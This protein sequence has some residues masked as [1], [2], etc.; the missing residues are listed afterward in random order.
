M[1]RAVRLTGDIELN[2]TEIPPKEEAGR[3]P[4]EEA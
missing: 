1:M 4:S 3:D 2:A